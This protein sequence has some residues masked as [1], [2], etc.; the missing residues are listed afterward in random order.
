MCVLHIGTHAFDSYLKNHS[1][2]KLRIILYYKVHDDA[3]PQG[4][5]IVVNDF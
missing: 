4:E 2:R 3:V 1:T 5:C